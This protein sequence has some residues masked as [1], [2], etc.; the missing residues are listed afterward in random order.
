MSIRKHYVADTPRVKVDCLGTGSDLTTISGAINTKILF[1][2]PDGIAGEWIATIE[3]NRYL[4][5]QISGVT[6]LD[7]AGEWD[8][9][10][11]IE[12]GN[13]KGKG[14]TQTIR[15]FDSFE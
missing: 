14:E 8:F 1:S 11:Y 9:Q 2:K 5:Y 10:A 3:S 6:E 13:F 4:I 12:L 7:Q 15:I